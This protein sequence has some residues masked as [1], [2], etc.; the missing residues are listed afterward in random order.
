MLVYPACHFKQ[1]DRSACLDGY[2][3][4]TAMDS[5]CIPGTLE[6]CCLGWGLG[7]MQ[8]LMKVVEIGGYLM[9]LQVSGEVMMSGLSSL[10]ILQ[11]V[12][13][14]NSHLG[15]LYFLRL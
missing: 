13:P 5:P 15:L 1:V 10:T 7:W 8:M 4:Y 11:Q 3:L 6:T 14:Q 9:G 12:L 2:V